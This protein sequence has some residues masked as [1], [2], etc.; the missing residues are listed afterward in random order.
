MVPRFDSDTKALG[1]REEINARG[2]A[3]DLE[4]WIFEQVE[5]RP[6]MRVLDLGCGRGKQVFALSGSVLPGGTIVGLDISEDAVSEVN[7]RAEQ[8]NLGHV[9]A[10]RG[11]LDD[12]VARFRGA[13]FDLVLS[14]Y[15]LYYATDMASLLAD[16]R[17]LVRPGGML[18]VSGPGKDTNREMVDLVNRL[19][20]VDVAKPIED[21]VEASV[22]GDVG[23]RYSRHDVVRLS[24]SIAFGSA[25]DVMRWWTNHNS[26]VPSLADAVARE[27]KA[28]FARHGSFS[29]TKNVLGARFHA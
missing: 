11:A 23:K 1:H 5:P 29:M 13:R 17:E 7:R 2:A 27:L 21:F 16:L 8:K 18:F 9:S 20:Y 12:C 22:V 15:A 14:T 26:F 24:N 19:A 4:A 3:Y 6:G 28:L 10:V 25:D